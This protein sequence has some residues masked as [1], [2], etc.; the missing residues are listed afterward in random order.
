M[1]RT[2]TRRFHVILLVVCSLLFSQLA[3]ANYVCPGGAEAGQG[4]MEMASG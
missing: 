4:V 3:L 1:L 2:T